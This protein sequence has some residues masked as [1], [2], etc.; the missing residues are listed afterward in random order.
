MSSV[1]R[2]RVATPEQLP[3]L[4]KLC[5]GSVG[6]AFA[7]LLLWGPAAC[8]DEPV[9]YLSGVSELFGTMP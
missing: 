1:S 5:V 7:L 4:A 9:G 2:E 3:I 6:F 8:V